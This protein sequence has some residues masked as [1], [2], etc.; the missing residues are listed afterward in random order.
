MKKFII[1]LLVI[2]SNLSFG[3]KVVH[4][5]NHILVINGS[6]DLTKNSERA[7]FVSGNQSIQT[8]FINEFQVVLG[9]LNRTRQGIV[10][11]E[12]VVKDDGKIDSVKFVKHDDPINDLEAA[13]L[14]SLT[15]GAWRP[16]QINGVRIS[17]KMLM[18]FYFSDNAKS[19][20]PI[21]L[22]SKATEYFEKKSFDNC[23]KYCNE[24]LEL[25]P[26]DIQSL[27]LKSLSLIELGFKD[28]ACETLNLAKNYYATDVE[29][30]LRDNC[31]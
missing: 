30:Y 24:A 17:E 13:R 4:N 9:R 16:G 23:I 19:K 20:S 21:K 27:K 29:E 6:W 14:L 2:I 3:Q 22:I 18:R 31:Y 26:F 7:Q 10:E 8:L 1:F 11:L 25:N 15:D 5:S 12:F 28:E